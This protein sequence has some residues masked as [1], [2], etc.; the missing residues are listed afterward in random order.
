MEDEEIK[1]EEAK[2]EEKPDKPEQAKP[3]P[4]PEQPNNSELDS[5]KAELSR[6]RTE[7]AA[8]LEAVKM[9]VD[10]RQIDYVLKL[11]EFPENADAKAITSAI[12]KVLD[13]VPAFKA[14]NSA[15]AKGFQIGA[16]APKQISEADAIAKAFGN[17]RKD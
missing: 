7:K 12:Q 1:K 6:I 16:D 14:E 8:A 17:T 3:E 10:S 4:E 2:P 5:L 13:D 15:K 11:A 9:G